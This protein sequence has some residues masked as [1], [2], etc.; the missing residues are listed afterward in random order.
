MSTDV[1]PAGVGFRGEVAE[2]YRRWRRGYPDAVIDALV[3]AFALTSDD[4]VVDLGCGTGQLAAPLA[5]RVREVLG[6]DPE[7]D[8]LAGAARTAAEH[9]VRNA[10]W[11]LGTDADLPALLAGRAVA[12]VTVGQALHWM[13]H[14]RLFADVRP[15][16]RPGGGIAVVTNGLPLWQQ[17][18]AWSVALLDVLQEWF[19][20]ALTATCGTDEAS[21]SRYRAAL[22]AAGFTVDTAVVEHTDELSA[23]AIV[24]GV[25]SATSP[26]TLPAPADRPEFERRVLAALEPHTP[27][28]EHVRVTV[29]T[30]RV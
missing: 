17:D 6:V 15:L 20:R 5:G 19:G 11:L 30:G 8:M 23:E 29:L 2:F 26:D 18:A 16:V 7:A 9:G 3:A 22:A 25:Y 4:T 1:P 28:V 12:A 24:G 13:D 10:R 21:A 27:H 14:E